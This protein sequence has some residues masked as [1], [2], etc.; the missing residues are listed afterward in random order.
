MKIPLKFLQVR[1]PDLSFLRWKPSDTLAVDLGTASIKVLQ[2]K[3][4][5]E[6]WR[7]V[8]WGILPYQGG[9]EGPVAERKLA[10]VSALREFL[11]NRQIQV[12]NVVS[13]VS[14]NAVI[15]RYVRLPKLSPQELAKSLRYEAEPYIPFNIAEVNLGFYTLGEVLEE[16]QKKLDTILV[17]AKKEVVDQ[18]LDILVEAGLR[19]III[20]VDAFALE[21]AYELTRQ[22]TS[23]P[24]PQETL[25]FVNIGASVTNMSIMEH[26]VSKVVRDVF[27]AGTTFTKAVQR[28]CQVD[29]K[30]AEELKRSIAL[31]LSPAEREAAVAQDQKQAL[32]ASTAMLGV[33]KDLLAEVQRS[34]DFYLAQGSDRSVQRV[35]LTGGGANVRNLDGYFAQEL[36]L[37]VEVFDPFQGIEGIPP[38]LEA[39]PEWHAQLT[40]AVGLAS[41]H[42]GDAKL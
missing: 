36:K 1:L 8:T 11:A 30:T 12:K 42:E 39:H 20:D 40:V 26:G 7:L 27:I 3:K 29:P 31:L 35:F 18:R 25:V 33:A 6:R 24:K 21:N 13:S 5:N 15:V 16:G 19:P 32:Q 37:P 28:Q 2:L 38:E 9:T 23:S 34:I 10:V 22:L 4:A 17:A 14:G 41:R